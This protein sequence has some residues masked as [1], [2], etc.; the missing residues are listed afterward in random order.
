VNCAGPQICG[1]CG[2]EVHGQTRRGLIDAGW[3]WARA[4]QPLDK[5]TADFVR[6]DEE[7]HAAAAE[8]VLPDHPDETLIDD[9]LITVR[10]RRVVGG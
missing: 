1:S 7:L 6:L 5:A 8:S 4:R 2:H 3:K 10:R 9:L